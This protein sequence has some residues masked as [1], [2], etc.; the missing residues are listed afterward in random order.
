MQTVT[1]LR[2]RRVLWALIFPLLLILTGCEM[3]TEVQVNE[4]N[5]AAVN[6]TVSGEKDLLP[7]S[8]SCDDVAKEFAHQFGDGATVTDESGDNLLTCKLSSMAQSI[9]KLQ[10][11]NV[12]V[13]RADD[14]F[15]VKA[16]PHE[17]IAEM[18][19]LLGAAD[20]SFAFTF[21]GAVTKVV[22]AI[23]DTDYE[24]A[25]NKVTFTDL[26]FYENDTTITA[27]ASAGNGSVT[28]W[29]VAIVAVLIIAAIIVWA[30]TKKR[31]SSPS[32]RR[33]ARDENAKREPPKN[34]AEQPVE[35]HRDAEAHSD[36]SR[37]PGSPAPYR[38]RHGQHDDRQP[39]TPA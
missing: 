12:D 20:F 27:G 3:H 7:Q 23:P 22:T 6:V 17:D 15:V 2:F 4:D 19:A 28:W 25:G 37:P 18:K 31:Q 29:I 8:V 1:T 34:P 13:T 11:L 26:N 36:D 38:G 14:E 39:P 32:A 16:T 5:T 21:P 35:A 33:A 30:L 9:K 10:H 24:I